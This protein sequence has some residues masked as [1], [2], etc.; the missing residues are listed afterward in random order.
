MEGQRQEGRVVCGICSKGVIQAVH[1]E[2]CEHVF[3][4]ACL[5]R[6]ANVSI[7]WFRQKISVRNARLSS[8]SCWGGI[9][10]DRW[11]R[12]GRGRRSTV[13]KM[14]IHWWGWNWT[15]IAWRFSKLEYCEDFSHR[16]FKSNLWPFINWCFFSDYC[17][18]LIA[19]FFRY[20]LDK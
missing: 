1:T 12:D 16:W 20:L 4:Y 14:V 2:S 18:P 7:W 13:K 9:R 8:T 11:G 3:C 19:N 5:S 6:W 17:C 10:E 15:G